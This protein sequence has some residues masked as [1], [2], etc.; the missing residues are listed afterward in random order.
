MESSEYLAAVRRDT[1]AFLAAA[2]AGLDAPVPSCPDWDVRALLVHLGGVHRW[3]TKIVRE[4][5]Q[6]RLPRDSTPAP[7]DDP[8]AWLAA[9]ADALLDVLKS[10]APDV[11]V[12]NWAGAP[13]VASFWSRRMAHETAV[14]RWD[15]ENAQGK[16]EPLGPPT[17]AADGLAEMVDTV[18]PRLA[19]AR[20]LSV[21]GSL[22]LHCT[23]TPGEWLVNVTDGVV[24]ASPEHGKGDVALRGPASDLWLAVTNRA[25]L[26][27]IDVFGD[28]KLARDWMDAFAF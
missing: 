11:A 22:H 17:L 9:G 7:D 28:Q 25:P 3:V 26:D 27:G 1:D 23:D 18:L 13:E 6:A 8:I 14:H 19:G 5:A 15:A 21:R 4:E 16:A 10:T 12:W 20:E 2:A 24:Q